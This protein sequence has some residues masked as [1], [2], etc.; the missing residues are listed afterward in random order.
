MPE[1]TATR[2]NPCPV[3]VWL[4]LLI[5]LV[6]LY[7]L[8][9][10]A[11]SKKAL[12]IQQDIQSRASESIRNNGQLMDVTVTTDGRDITLSG[13]VS[14]EQKLAEAENL[15]H[16]ILGARL[17]SNQLVVS[18]AS[19]TNTAKATDDQVPTAPEPEITAP[20]P[21]EI[22]AKVEPMP[23]EFAP[24]EETVLKK[25]ELAQQVKES[26][27]EA[28][29]E[30]AEVE[31]TKQKLSQ[32]DFSNITF[33]KNSTALTGDAQ[34]TLDQVIS[35][36]LENPTV[37][38]HVNGHTD[39]SGNPELNFKL[40]KQRA[41]SVFDYLVN[42]GVDGDRIQADGFGDQFPI[43]PNDTQAGRI[44]NRRIEIKVKNGE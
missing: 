6:L 24:L 15:A 38:I 37:N 2:Q 34:A 30:L 41:Q 31:I 19:T 21:P 3:W 32:L 13:H 17:I 22:L 12:W 33:E 14:S 4:I 44:K 16:Q 36:L 7:L 11:I 28:Q 23:E 42:A 10:H 26:P 18:D 39:S 43:A 35:A 5:G 27:T 1:N 40:S 25:Q 29:I 9:N 8:Y 20:E